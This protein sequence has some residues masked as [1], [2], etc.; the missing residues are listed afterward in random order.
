MGVFKSSFLKRPG[1]GAMGLRVSE[2]KV[3]EPGVCSCDAERLGRLSKPAAAMVAV[4]VA[5][6]MS[7]RRRL[8]KR[9]T[10]GSNE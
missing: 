9:G 7:G 10:E 4:E 1:E 5:E 6:A 2:G 8:R 3:P